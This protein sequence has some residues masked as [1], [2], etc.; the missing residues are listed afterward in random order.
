M[1]RLAFGHFGCYVVC[2]NGVQRGILIFAGAML[3]LVAIAQ[4]TDYAGSMWLSMAT[5][6]AAVVCF[7]L[8]ARSRSA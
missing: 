5:F 8:S 7:V 3:V 4:G 2:V 1:S 6:I